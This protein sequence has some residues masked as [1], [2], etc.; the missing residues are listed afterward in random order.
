[1]VKKNS[2]ALDE[3]L[4]R[5]SFCILMQVFELQ[6]QLSRVELQL[7]EQEVLVQKINNLERSNRDLSDTLSALREKHHE[8]KT[9]R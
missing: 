1:M 2:I 8:E 4:L 9:T 3:I 7:H 5:T 6:Q